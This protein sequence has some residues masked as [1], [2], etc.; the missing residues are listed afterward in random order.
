MVTADKITRQACLD[1]VR[2]GN[3][4]ELGGIAGFGI[5]KGFTD[6]TGDFTQGIEVQTERPYHDRAE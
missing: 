2:K 6:G 3:N 1:G 5:V 4:K